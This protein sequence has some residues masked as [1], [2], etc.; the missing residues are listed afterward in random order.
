MQLSFFTLSCLTF[1]YRF[2]A[3]LSFFFLEFLEI[4]HRFLLFKLF[5]MLVF[6]FKF[7]TLTTH[8]MLFFILQTDISFA[9]FAQIRSTT[10]LL[11]V[12]CVHL[13][14]EFLLAV[15]A[16]LRLHFTMSFMVTENYFGSTEGT[17]LACNRFVGFR[18]M[19]LLVSFGYDFTTFFALVVH[20]STTYFV[21]SEFTR[22]NVPLTIRAL[23]SF[24]FD[25]YFLQQYISWLL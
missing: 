19:L 5:F 20:S 18:I 6:R 7:I 15:P 10:T 24:S 17:V 13:N 21:H 2:L 11:F 14:F 22:F 9:F 16:C 1:F 4:I 8:H 23:L 25:H 12:I 3:P